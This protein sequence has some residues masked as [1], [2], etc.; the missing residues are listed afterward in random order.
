MSTHFIYHLH[1]SSLSL[2]AMLTT[3]HYNWLNPS[4]HKYYNDYT[5]ALPC[6]SKLG[7]LFLSR[8]LYH[9]QEKRSDTR[10]E[11]SLYEIYSA[12]RFWFLF[13]VCPHKFVF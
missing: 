5:T 12:E 9:S 10:D 3:K 7:V 4:E 2:P 6:L 8:R 13:F 11:H 1:L